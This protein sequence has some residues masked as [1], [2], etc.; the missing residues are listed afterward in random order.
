MRPRRMVAHDFTRRR[1]EELRGRITEFAGE[2]SQA[3]RQGGAPGDLVEAFALPLPS[4]MI[5]ELLGVPYDLRDQFHVLSLAIT[6]NGSTEDET[7]AAGMQLFEMLAGIIELRT[8]EPADDIISRLVHEQ[9][10]TGEL[11]L[12]ELVL[13]CQILLAAGH[14]TT[15]G[16]ISLGMCLLLDNPALFARMATIDDPAKLALAVDELLRYIDIAH[17]GRRKVAVEDIEIGG[18]IVRAGEGM[19]LAQN[20]AGRDPLAF[21]RPDEVVLDRDP[22]R[23]LAFGFGPHQCLGM[24]LAR[25]TLQVAF[26]ALFE[27][28]PTMRW[29][30]GRRDVEFRS[31]GI[32]YGIDRMTVAW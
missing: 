27:G 1:A 6:S 21:E 4:M 28:F 8:N 30:E 17:L 5:C 20:I 3:M 10:L 14:E 9:L 16:M 12:S 11:T 25:V 32:S 31:D 22:N 24:S 29:P 13:M 19:I 2:L 26:K 7:R 18:V 23:H 15:A